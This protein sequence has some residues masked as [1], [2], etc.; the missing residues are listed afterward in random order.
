[1]LQNKCTTTVVTEEVLNPL[2]QFQT[3]NNGTSWEKI[4]WK[5]YYFIAQ[6]RRG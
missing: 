2:N 4:A 5:K 6:I 3:D 1:M